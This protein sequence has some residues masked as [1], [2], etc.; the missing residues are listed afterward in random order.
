[1]KNLILL[2]LLISVSGCDKEALPEPAHFSITIEALDA[3]CTEIWLKATVTKFPA[4]VRLLRD[5]RGVSDCRILTSDSLLVDDGLLPNRTYTYQLQKLGIDSSVMVTSESVKV[6]TM[7]TT[8]NEWVFSMST[9]GDRYSSLYD[10]AIINDT[11]IWAVGELYLKD[12]TGAFGKKYNAVHWDGRKW[13]YKRIKLLYK[14]NWIIPYLNA[15]FAFSTD[16]IWM[17]AGI[18]VHGDGRKWR[19]Y[20]LFDMGI[21]KRTDGSINKI[22]GSESSDL[23]FVGERGTIVH[24]VNGTWRRMESGTTLPIQGVFG[25]WN[26]QSEKNEVFCV[27]EDFGTPGGSKVLSLKN[28]GVHEVETY[29]LLS[30]GI[31]D[32]WFV[33]GKKYFVSGSGVWRSYSPGG[34]WMRNSSLPRLFT[35]SIDGQ[36][37]NDIVVC[38]AFGLLA[39]YN[40][41]HWRTYFPFTSG[42]FTAVQIKNNFIVAVGG[43]GNQAVIVEGKR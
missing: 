35:T 2:F 27:A 43:I 15:V 26:P 22:W 3:S 5:G 10:V 25:S 32:I 4:T 20:H 40:G 36:G 33:P 13:E 24:Y 31:W 17:S 29:G 19:Q 23:W 39:H 6:T 30:Y 12:S 28:S 11:D 42:S 34:N 7:D 21:L 14:G 8:S 18:P 9:L 1:M 16:D 38:G 37:L 41:M